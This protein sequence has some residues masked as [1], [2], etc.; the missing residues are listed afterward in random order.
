VAMSN[1]DVF[2]VLTGLL[3]TPGQF[4][5][6]LADDYPAACEALGLEPWEAGYGLV[7]GQDADG[8]RWTLVTH[9]AALVACAVAA[10]DCGLDYRL[11]PPDRTVVATLP[12]WPLNLAVQTLGLPDP[13]DPPGA[14]EPPLTPPDLDAWGPAQRRMGADEIGGNW[15]AWRGRTGTE[16]RFAGKSGRP[17]HQG[18]ARVMREVAAYV[19]DRPPVGRVRSTPADAGARTLR[20]DGPGWSLVARTD[21]MAFVLLDDEPGEVIPIGRGP[22][23]PALLNDLDRLAR[24]AG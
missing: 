14:E 1:P 10:W 11:D 13:H 5:S 12:G 8:A 15:Q 19:S 20:A 6:A 24:G 17:G 2:H 22:R 21:D 7:L 23:L 3:L 4:P 9:D 18:L 16:I